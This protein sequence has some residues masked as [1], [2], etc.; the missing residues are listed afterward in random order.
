MRDFSDAKLSRGRKSMM[1]IDHVFSP[2]VLDVL[3]WFS[4]AV[5]SDLIFKV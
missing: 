4:D 3:N 5:L 1:T 2:V